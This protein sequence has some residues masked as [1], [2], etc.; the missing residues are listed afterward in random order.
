MAFALVS[1][2][3]ARVFFFSPA[4]WF[5]QPVE[6]LSS[7]EARLHL[8]LAKFHLSFHLTTLCLEFPDGCLWGRGLNV[9]SK[10]WALENITGI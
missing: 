10:L 5:H 9:G 3:L 8:L 2:P 6:A 4:G 7:K 1:V